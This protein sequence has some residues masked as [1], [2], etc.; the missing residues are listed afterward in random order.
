VRAA[1]RAGG[2]SARPRSAARDAERARILAGLWY[3]AKVFLGLRLGLFVLGLVATGLLPPHS[4]FPGA[5]PPPV[6]VPGW[7]AHE[8]TAGWHNLFTSFE[9]Q[10][11]LWFLRI[12]TDGYASGDGSAA[13][14]P[15]YP[16]LVRLLSF[17]FGG[18]PLAAA[19][20]LSNA[21]FLGAL[22][23][24][25]FLTAS[26]LGSEDA[27]RRSVLYVAVFPT[28]FFF[29]APYSESLFLLLAATAFWAARRGRWPL[30]GL[31]AAL[32]AA[33]RSIGVLL[34]VALAIEAVHQRRERVRAG[35]A[36]DEADRQLGAR[37][38]WSAAGGLGLLAYLAYWGI[39]Q[40]DFLAPLTRQGDWQRT[41][42]F[43]LVTLWKATDLAFHLAGVYFGAYFQL[44]WLV[45][46]P[47]LALAGYAAWRFRPAYGFFTWASLLVPLSFIFEGRPLMSV[48]RFA[49]VQF[50][51]AWA[52]ADLTG[53]RRLPHDAVVAVSAALLGLLTILFVNW[54]FTF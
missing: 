43:P 14:F 46:V 17:L 44:D 24:L 35:A 10:D 9:R 18:H 21:A 4:Q 23:V 50:P 25:Y 20:V 37:L 32:A 53:R 22:F 39:A 45:T 6:D 19:L 47:C 30:A 41:L 27:A 38:L 1:T 49:L 11:A 28:S 5:V 34:V 7:P 15:L 33:T 29:L 8:I 40:G 36:P 54:Y 16:L 48:P 12:A 2:A 26:E 52:L 13:F 3:C 42:T 31:A 51:I